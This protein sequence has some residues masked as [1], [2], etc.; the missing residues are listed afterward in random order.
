[1]VIFHRY[2][3]LPEGSYAQK[4][5]LSSCDQLFAILCRDSVNCK[6]PIK[7]YQ[8]ISLRAQQQKPHGTADSV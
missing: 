6:A 1:M 3:S 5:G 8:G 4:S 7:G 2:V